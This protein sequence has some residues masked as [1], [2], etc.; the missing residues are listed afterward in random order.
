[1]EAKTML[2]QLAEGIDRV[3]KS[4]GATGAPKTRKMTP[5]ALMAHAVAEIQKAAGEPPERAKRRLAALSRAVD[6]A[7]QAY[8]DT[9]SEDIEVEVFEEETTARADDSEKET[10]PVAL[11]AALGNAAFASNPE[12]L[13]KALGRLAKDL[14]GLRAAAPAEKPTAEGEKVAKE[15]HAEWPFDMNTKTFREGVH[16]AEDGPAWG[17]DPGRVDATAK[18]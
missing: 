4:Q 10:S 2:D 11:V 16:K 13:H 5:D 12:D 8:V 14:A 1:M 15:H 6:T 18:P 7:K 9:A 17:Y 3:L